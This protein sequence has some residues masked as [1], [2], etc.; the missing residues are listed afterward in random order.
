MASKSYAGVTL[1]QGAQRAPRALPL[2]RDPVAEP[3]SFAAQRQDAAIAQ[4]ASRAS[5]STA[6]RPL[7]PVRRYD[8][9]ARKP[10]GEILTH[11]VVAPATPLFEAAFCAFARG[12]LIATDQGLCAVE[13][14]VPGM[15]IDTIGHGIRP[16][17]WVG[18]M[19]TLPGIRQDHAAT[20]GMT[21]IMADS[22]GIGR[23]MVDIIVSPA[24]RMLHGGRSAQSDPVLRAVA[25]TEDGNG[26][27]RIMPQRAVTTYHLCLDRHAAI[28]VSGIGM[29]SFHPGHA[30]H[31]QMGPAMMALFLSLFPHIHAPGDFGP[32]A[33]DRAPLPA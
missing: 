11:Q 19:T 29:E 28:N 17:E 24:A 18:A 2:A 31:R 26:A 1:A 20:A 5:A 30:L 13:D 4:P 25:G 33:Y 10:S 8:I 32:L 6:P 21:R 3:H 15:M 16:L 14:L 9:C 27:I 12:T 23:P 7:P 22:F